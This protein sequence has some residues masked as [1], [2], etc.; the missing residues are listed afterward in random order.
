MT[1]A[2]TAQRNAS[3]QAVVVAAVAK[4]VAQARM[5]R[6]KMQPQ[7]PPQPQQQQQQ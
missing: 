3:K 4:G 5:D 7:Q 2:S 1:T 6:P